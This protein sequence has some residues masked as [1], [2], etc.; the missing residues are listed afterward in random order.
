MM[1]EHVPYKCMHLGPMKEVSRS[2][3]EPTQRVESL[4]DELFVPTGKD[5]ACT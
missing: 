1:D 5:Y 3:F 4:H 2:K